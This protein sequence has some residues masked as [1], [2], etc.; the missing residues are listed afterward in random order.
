MEAKKF[1]EAD[2]LD[3]VFENRN[4]AYG[5]YELRKHYGFPRDPKKKFGIECVYSPEQIRRPA[6]AGRRRPR[7]RPAGDPRPA[8]AG[9]TQR[10][11]QGGRLPGC[12]GPAALA[13]AGRLTSGRPRTQTA[14]R[15]GREAASRWSFSTGV[16]SPLD[17][18]GLLRR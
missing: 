10:P 5:S 6:A 3:I 9:L 15:P 2:Y 4:K 12:R 17:L 11:G 7:R 18:Y 1:L 16:L 13:A 8:A 14:G